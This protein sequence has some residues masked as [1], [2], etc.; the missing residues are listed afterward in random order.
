MQLLALL[1]V[2]AAAEPEPVLD[3]ARLDTGQG[4]KVEIVRQETS[5]KGT[6]VTIVLNPKDEQFTVDLN[7]DGTDFRH[8]T[9]LVKG[10][11]A[12]DTVRYFPTMKRGAVDHGKHYFDLMKIKGVV[13][14][15]S[16]SDCSI[17]FKTPA[18]LKLLPPSGRLMFRFASGA[19][20]HLNSGAGGVKK[21][22]KK[23]AE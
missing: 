3:I 23:P 13:V 10:A 15:K 1:L 18:A 16:G 22:P 19:A 12:W 8:V 21:A 9:I 11:T 5:S 7:W 6:E 17:E 20:L 2:L 4:R 14:E